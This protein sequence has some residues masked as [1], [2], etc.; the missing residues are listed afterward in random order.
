MDCVTS[1]D[2]T[3]ATSSR[4]DH[5]TPVSRQTHARK[6]AKSS[7]RSSANP[8]F[9]RFERQV[10]DELRPIGVLESLIID[11]V[12]QTAW[13]LKLTLDRKSEKFSDASGRSEPKRIRPDASE[14]AAKAFREA[15]E[16]FETLRNSRNP[17]HA[18]IPDTDL[19]E[20]EPNEWPFMPTD[21][22]QPTWRD[23]LV[24]DDEVSDES[25]VVKGTWVTVN[26]V[27]SLIVDGSTWADILRSHP[28]LSEDDI[29]ACVCYATAEENRLD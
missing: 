9:L 28:E 24:F 11:Q 17:S 22:F 29:R 20:I 15:I 21:N 12:A 14:R 5:P 16:T 26:Q 2:S 3:A 19:D 8:D 4:S 10:R 27:V 7:D 18:L 25:P 6:R 1:L 13:T 23:R